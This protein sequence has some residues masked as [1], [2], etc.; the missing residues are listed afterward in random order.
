MLLLQNEWLNGEGLRKRETTQYNL[1]PKKV[2]YSLSLEQNKDNPETS[3]S[4][5]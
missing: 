5:I 4:Y 3:T 2:W 1:L